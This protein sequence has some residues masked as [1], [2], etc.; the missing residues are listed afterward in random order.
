MA[1]VRKKKIKNI[2][3]YVLFSLDDEIIFKVLRQDPSTMCNDSKPLNYNCQS[4]DLIHGMPMVVRSSH[5]PE[6]SVGEEIKIYVGG[7]HNLRGSRIHT[8]AVPVPREL[9]QQYIDSIDLALTEWAANIDKFK[10]EERG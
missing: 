4:V 5:S 6:I 9:H 7:R 2:M 8:V 10:P 1:L 3:D